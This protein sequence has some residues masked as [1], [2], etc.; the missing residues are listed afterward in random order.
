MIC[1]NELKQPSQKDWKFVK[2][3]SETVNWHFNWLR[4]LAEKNEAVLS[5]GI[6][7]QNNYWKN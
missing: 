3:L 5:G 7:I 2:E 1:L 6:E 4:T